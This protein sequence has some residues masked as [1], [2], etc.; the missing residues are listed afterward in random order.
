MSDRQLVLGFFADELAADSAAQALKHS[1]IA[2]GDAI[3][4]LVLDSEGELKQDKVGARSSGE[5]AGIGGALLLL[6]G[7]TAFG[8]GIVGGAAAG[9]LHH[10]GLG[11]GDAD[12]ARLTSELSSG[13]AAVGVLAEVDTARAI[14]DRMMELGGTPPGSSGHRWARA[15]GGSRDAAVSRLLP[16]LRA[17]HAAHRTHRQV[18]AAAATQAPGRPQKRPGKYRLAFEEAEL[19]SWGAS[20]SSRCSLTCVPA[21]YRAAPRDSEPDGK[22]PQVSTGVAGSSA[23]VSSFGWRGGT[24]RHVTGR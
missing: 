23:G 18:A 19:A 5:G 21:G 6:L 16:D 24:R 3:G 8:V 12:K 1:G 20:R 11:L 9:A 17:G 15:G 7:P 4:I 22:A 2:E 10:K 14:A 13:K